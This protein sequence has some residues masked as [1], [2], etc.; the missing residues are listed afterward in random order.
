MICR[1]LFPLL[2]LVVVGCA[3]SREPEL[4]AAPLVDLEALPAAERELGLVED[5]ERSLDGEASDALG[6][7]EVDAVVRYRLGR[8]L[9][10][11]CTAGLCT[12]RFMNGTMSGRGPTDVEVIITPTGMVERAVLD[13]VRD[14]ADRHRRPGNLGIDADPVGAFAGRDDELQIAHLRY[15]KLDVHVRSVPG[16]RPAVTLTPN[17]RDHDIDGAALARC[18]WSVDASGYDCRDAP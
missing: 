15:A 17:G 18:R 6:P 11:S 2:G 5:R 7:F 12:R 14:Y 8:F 10:K 16:S 1:A 3:A 9:G 4:A 13:V